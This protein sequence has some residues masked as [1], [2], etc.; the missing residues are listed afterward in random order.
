MESPGKTLIT[1]SSLL[2]GEPIH[3]LNKN[4]GLLETHMDQT[5]VIMENSLCK[6]ELMISVLSQ[7]LLPMIQFSAA[8]EAAEF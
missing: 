6:G 4:I 8:K 7:R 2:A 3:K 5:G 1:Q